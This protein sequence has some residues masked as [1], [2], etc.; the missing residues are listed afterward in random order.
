M[1]YYAKFPSV[2]PHNRAGSHALLTRAPL[3]PDRNPTSVRLA[4]VRHAASVRSEPGSNSQVHPRPIIGSPILRPTPHKGLQTFA[5]MRKPLATPPG[6]TPG[7]PPSAH[8]FPLLHTLK[9]Q[10]PNDPPTA[11]GA[12]PIRPTPSRV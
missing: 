7:Q 5:S 11:K 2:I 1:R 10:T 3:L 4:C 6:S 12:A 9:Q 8:P